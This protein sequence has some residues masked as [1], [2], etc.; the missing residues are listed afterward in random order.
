MLQELSEDYDGRPEEEKTKIPVA[1]TT[2]FLT[3][4]GERRYIVD[5]HSQQNLTSMTW[6]DKDDLGK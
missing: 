2:G 1:F 6:F 5:H 4:D 3:T